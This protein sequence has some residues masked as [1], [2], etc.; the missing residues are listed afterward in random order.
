MTL[1]L[2]HS[3]FP[4]TVY[5]H[6]FILLFV[7]VTAQFAVNIDFGKTVYLLIRVSGRNETRRPRLE[8]VGF[9]LKRI[10]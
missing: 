9:Y 3:E 5:E 10:Q 1:Q 4:Y 2:L 7:T 8:V 6:N